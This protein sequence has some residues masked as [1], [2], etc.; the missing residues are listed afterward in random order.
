MSVVLEHATMEAHIDKP[1]VTGSQIM[2]AVG[3][4][5]NLW[6][7]IS[8]VTVVEVCELLYRICKTVIKSEKV[9]NPVQNT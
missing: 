3:G 9:N 7:G 2:G 5:L 6:I 4:T 8:F 1:K